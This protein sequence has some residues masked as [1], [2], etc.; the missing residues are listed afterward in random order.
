[1]S[2]QTDAEIDQDMDE[3]ESKTADARSRERGFEAII[4]GCLCLTLF[5]ICKLLYNLL[6]RPSLDKMVFLL[7]STIILGFFIGNLSCT[8]DCRLM[9]D[10]KSV[11]IPLLRDCKKELSQ[12]QIQYNA[13]KAFDYTYA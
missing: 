5:G 10:A 4:L 6:V 1:M 12:N 7:L 3:L 8:S 13:Y 2:D 9:C 11:C